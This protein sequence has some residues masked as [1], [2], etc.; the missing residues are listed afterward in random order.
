MANGVGQLTAYLGLDAADYTRGLTAAELKARRFGE[1]IGSAINTGAKLAS[2]GFASMVT[3]ASGFYAFVNSQA[4]SIA[5]FQDLADKVGDSAEQIATLQTAA[6]LSGTA[7]DTVAAASIKLTASLAKSDDEAKGAA[8]GL[9]AIGIEVGAFQKLSPVEQIDAVAKALAGFED[10]A[11][12]TAA[13]VQI[14]GKSG[15]ELIPFLNDLAEEGERQITLTA[16]QIA[17]ADQYSKQLARNKTEVKQLAQVV[18]AESIPA[19]ADFTGALVDTGKQLL[20][21][22]KG[23]NDL[24]NNKS[25]RDFADGAALVLANVV[26]AGIQVAGVLEIIG[27]G[28]GATAALAVATAK[29][30]FGSLSQIADDAA[31]DIRRVWDRMKGPGVADALRARMAA[32]GV[33]AAGGTAPP[34]RKPRID[35]SG[36]RTG[37]SG[38][39]GDDATKKLLD[40]QN[41]ILEDAIKR[42]QSL[43]QSRNKM[44][45]LYNGENLIS[46]EQYF[47]GRRSAQAEALAQ[48]Q[49]LLDQQIAN[50]EAYQ[51]RATKATERE[52][53][54]GKINALLERKATLQREAGQQGVELAF[55]EARAYRD[56]QRTMEGVNAQILELQGNTEAAARIRFDTGNADLLARLSAQGDTQGTAQ[57]ETLRQL[58]VAQAGYAQQQTAAAEVQARLQIEEGR[59]NTAREFGFQSELEGLQKLGVARQAAVQQMESIVAAQEA[60]AR[61]SGSPALVLQAEQARAALEQLRATA[62]PLAQKFDEIF[63]GSFSTAFADFVNGTKSAGDAFKSFAES[64]SQQIT[65]LAAQA[66]SKQIFGSLFGGASGGGGLGSIFAGIFGGGRA[67][68]G[69]VSPGRVYEV[70]ENGPETYERNGRTYLLTGKRGGVITPNT[71]AAGGS[72]TVNQSFPPGTNMKTIEQAAA[73]SGAAVRRAMARGTA[74]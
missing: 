39:G 22:G 48:E 11:A 24:A 33:D 56:L 38:G 74:G 5:G 54:Q 31:N 15:A 73:A 26:D 9:K 42:E 7:L 19:F 10:G 53:A 66:V 46:F 12:K 41:K 13:A 55:Q 34:A 64:V 71:R 8:A 58:T 3:A 29:G 70:A 35:T 59:I 36:F 20:G 62:D 65:A 25:I 63:Q 23:A 57:V 21:I 72:V 4:D 47:S 1:S 30:E 40:N 68:G 60:I 44:L 50:L 18:A 49:S 14:F 6:D 2:A 61:A 43:L 67:V 28:L 16:E 37:S 32:R 17:V 27:K 52:E 51:S 45:D 69:A